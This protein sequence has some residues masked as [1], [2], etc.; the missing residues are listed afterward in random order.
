MAQRHVV[1]AE[2]HRRHDPVIGPAVS[3]A[4]RELPDAALPLQEGIA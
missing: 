3:L 1:V 2:E 4:H